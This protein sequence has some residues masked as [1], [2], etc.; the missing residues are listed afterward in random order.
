L[1]LSFKID[2]K[3]FEKKKRK[4]KE[5]YPPLLSGPAAHQLH[6][7]AAHAPALFSFF[8]P[9]ADRPAPPVS[10][11]P[12]PFLSSS[13]P[14]LRPARRRRDSRRAPPPSPFLSS[15]PEPAN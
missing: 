2:L 9:L 6:P 3:E 12:I 14:L 5:T 8:F 10:L 1:N 11:L 4:K 15:S 7:A 13:S